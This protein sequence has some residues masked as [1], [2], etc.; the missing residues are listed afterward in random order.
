MFHI[1][2]KK[3]IFYSNTPLKYVLNQLLAEIDQKV[4]QL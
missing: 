1:I 4:L 2:V 3:Y